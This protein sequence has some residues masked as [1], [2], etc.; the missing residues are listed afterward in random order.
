MAKIPLHHLLEVIRGHVSNLVVRRRPDDAREQALLASGLAGIH[1]LYAELAAGARSR[2]LSPYNFALADCL[3][4]PV[5][6]R[7]ERVG[8]WIRV[9][10]SDNIRVDKVHVTVYAEDGSVL[11]RGLALQAA[12]NW[13]EYVTFTEGK[14][15]MAEAWDLPGNRAHFLL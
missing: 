12:E 4:P 14:R 15:V 9:Q 6:H 1:P 13:W 11:E 8:G 10:A 2:W 7:I 5:I 3:K